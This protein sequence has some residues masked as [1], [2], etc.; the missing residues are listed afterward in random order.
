MDFIATTLM[1]DR[2]LVERLDPETGQPVQ[3][4]RGYIQPGEIIPLDDQAQIDCL[5]ELGYIA[6]PE[7]APA[8]E[9]T[10]E[11]TPKKRRA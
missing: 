1:Y 11:A 2:R 7:I 3:V 10:E 4:E 6:Q 8:A 5:L 9:P